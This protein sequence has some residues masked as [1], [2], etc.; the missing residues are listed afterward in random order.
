VIITNGGK[1]PERLRISR[2]TGVT[3]AN[4]GSAYTAVFR[5]C[6]GVG[7]WLHRLSRTVTLPAGIAEA[8]GF[9]VTVPAGTPP[10]QYLAG[11]A[12]ELAAVPRALVVGSHGR[13]TAKAIIVDQI[14]VGVAITVGPLSS[15]TSRLRIAGAAGQFVFRTPRLNIDLRNMGQMFAPAAGTASCDSA[16]RHYLFRVFAGTVLP[17]ERATIAVNA[18][19]VGPGTALRCVLRLRYGRGQVA[20]WSG[21]I[22]MPNVPGARIVHTGSGAY[23]VLPIGGVPLWAIALMV[24][25]ALVLAVLVALL[26]NR[27]RQGATGRGRPPRAP[28]PSGTPNARASNLDSLLTGGDPGDPAGGSSPTGREWPGER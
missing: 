17:H 25:G 3:A 12:A 24:R 14:I 23:S 8:I 9:S 26:V 7:C 6:A 1:R 15:L 5:R 27:R 13:A 28:R 20:R 10:G 18:P 16:G 2:A 19:G 22:M 21:M 11:I 4:G